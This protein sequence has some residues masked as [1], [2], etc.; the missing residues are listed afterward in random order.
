[1]CIRDSNISLSVITGLVS[2][3]KPFVLSVYGHP[4]LGNHFVAG[5]GYY[6]NGSAAS[7]IV[8][9]GHGNRNVYINVYATSTNN[10]IG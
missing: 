1:M 4:T 9:D 8:N 5:Y 2:N 7:A 3:N 6:I 10:T